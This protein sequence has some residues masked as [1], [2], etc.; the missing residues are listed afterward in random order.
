MIKKNVT[1]S[2]TEKEGVIN[3]STDVNYWDEKKGK[4]RI[5]SSK[6]RISIYR[7]TDLIK[8][9]GDKYDD[10]GRLFKLINS[11]DANN[12]IGIYDKHLKHYQ[13]V[14]SRQMLYDLL[15]IKSRTTGGNFYKKLK[16]IELLKEWYNDEGQTV[17]YISPIYTMADRGITLT[18]YK[19]FFVE[20]NRVLPYKAKMALQALCSNPAADN[21]QVVKWD[22]ADNIFVDG[23]LLCDSV[24]EISA[25]TE[26]EKMNI[27]NEYIL[28]DEP[29]KTYQILGK[30]MVAHPVTTNNDTYFLVNG[31]N[32]YKPTK[33][34]NEDVAEYRSW[35][36]DIDCG[37][38]E[39]GNY[40][41]LEEVS[42][43]KQQ[44]MKV[45]NA[46]P[47][48]TAITDTR[49]GYHIYF[50]SYGVTDPVIWQ[51]LEDKLINITKIADS[52]VRDAARVLRIPGSVW[53]KAHTGLDPYPVSILQA[54]KQA[55]DSDS[56]NQQLDDCQVKVKAAAETYIAMYPTTTIKSNHNNVAHV[57]VTADRSDRLQA[58]M[59]LSMD[60]FTV[61]E[62]V[63]EVEDVNGYLHQ[64][65]LAE[66]LQIANPSSFVCILHDDHN[67][68][69]TI[70]NNDTGYRYYCASDDCT[71]HGDGKGIDII[72]VVMAL[73]DCTYKQAVNYLSRLYKISQKKVA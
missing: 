5:F 56:F 57:N 26:E 53:I 31:M 17:F 45:I 33:P 66:F 21:S 27:F 51:S 71:G 61:S 24:K 23:V 20:L 54:N 7:D 62:A 39:T 15:G 12:M 38:D 10:L 11:M 3:Y 1:S 32:D 37:K 42:R 43:R 69:A 63:E 55:Y 49:N 8:A 68:S 40:F 16:E 18:V 48:P 67:P 59:D 25:Q 34:K 60:T 35:F 29:A 36:L 28:L 13:P 14:T 46:L 41:T 4:Y 6:D 50:A 44:I 9:F 2:F 65:N 70:Y 22:D 72:D 19:L 64:V 73:S 58:I 52:A 30:G 47:T